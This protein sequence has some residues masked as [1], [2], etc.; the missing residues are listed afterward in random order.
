MRFKLFTIL[1]FVFLFLGFTPSLLNFRVF[2]DEDFDIS[3]VAK[4]TVA[5]NGETTVAQTVSVKNK[6]EFVYTPS[7]TISVGFSD[8][9]NLAS[10][11]SDGPIENSIKDEN[12]GKKIELTFPKRVVG[13]G[14]VNQFT[15]SFVT[16]QVTQGKG[17]VW[18]VS[19]PGLSEPETF[20]A[21]SAQVIVPSAFGP[22]NIIKPYKKFSYGQTYSFT[23]D[24]I[25]KSGIFIIFGD[26]QFYTLDLVYHLS[27]NELLPIKTEIALPPPTS[28]QDVRIKSID[29]KPQDVYQDDDGNWLAVYTL[30]ARKN[31]D[32]RVKEIVKLSAIPVFTTGGPKSY[33][34]AENKYWEKNL[35]EIQS[36]A[37]T[38]NSPQDIYNYVV[39]RLTY[40]FEKVSLDNK[41]LGAAGV[42]NRP[43]FAVCLEFT[44]LFVALARAKGIPARAVEGYALTE[45]SKLR[46]LSL[47]SDILHS[48]PEYYDAESKQWIMV[49]PTWGNTTHGMDYFNTLD[50]DHIAF[51]VKGKSSTYPV[52]AGGYK[53]DDKSRDLSVSVGGE[54][55]FIDTYQSSVSANFPQSAMTGL[56]I[57]GSVTV[58]NLGTVPM[59][60]KTLE[61]SSELKPEIQSFSV[62]TLPPYASRTIPVEFNKT[63]LLTSKNFKVKI[64]F[65]GNSVFKTIKVGI[66][67]SYTFVILGGILIVGS[68][69][70]AKITYKTWSIYIQRRK[71][72]S[73]LR[74]E[75]KRP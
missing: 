28:Y 56:P 68:I 24:E 65:D 67:P 16:S 40:N 43:D 30:P 1:G 39:G 75:G 71:G 4:Y 58:T 7:Y 55:N 9:R 60:G 26:T 11:N 64:S 42:L 35:G 46:P 66:L 14:S 36:I 34:T 72:E 31:L 15:V 10:F 70:V 22:P 20:D 17:S 62:E 73:A 49:D 59:S 19:I 3:T 57:I 18:E 69:I 13:I 52:P 21:Y 45:N 50:F 54:E 33:D 47:V 25:G 37:K 32:V 63:P 12:G 41:R 51:V 44:D 29:P 5:A 61:I 74:R 27:N 48:W 8:V 38:L 2:A 6:K 23:R 53:I